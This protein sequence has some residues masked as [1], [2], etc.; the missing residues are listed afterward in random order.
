[1]GWGRVCDVSTNL[2]SQAGRVVGESERTLYRERRKERGGNGQFAES[3]LCC[4]CLCVSV[5][6]WSVCARVRT[7][8]YECVYM[9][10]G[11]CVCVGRDVGG[12][13]SGEV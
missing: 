7:S 1:M 13:V 10:I 8:V 5:C 4:V 12:D 9:Y 6:V 3:G 11:V 2:F